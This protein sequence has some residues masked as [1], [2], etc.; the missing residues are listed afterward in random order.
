[1]KKPKAEVDNILEVLAT[2]RKHRVAETVDRASGI[3]PEKVRSR[4]RGHTKLTVE[5]LSALLA[6]MN[7]DPVEF[8]AWMEAGFHPE[9]YLR[10]L[11]KKR[12]SQVRHLRALASRAPAKE[13]SAE[14]IREQADGLED[15][16]PFDV[17]AAREGAL[18]I[19]RTTEHRPAVVDRDSLCEAW[20]IV[21]AIQRSRGRYSSAAYC[22]CRSLVMGGLDEV[23]TVRRALIFQ[24]IAYL[25]SDQGDFEHAEQVLGVAL[26]TSTKADEWRVVGRVLV[27]TGVLNG[28]RARYEEAIGAYERSLRLMPE[29]E[30]HACFSAYQGLGAAWAFRGELKESLANLKS[31]LAVLDALPSPPPILKGVVIWLR[32]EIQLLR[33][34]LPAAGRGFD[35]VREI[36]IDQ[37]MRPIDIALISLRLAKVLLLEGNHAEL[38]ELAHQM[39]ALLGPIERQNRLVSA[40]YAEFMSLTLRGK[41]TAE[42]L[43]SLYRR[44]H[45]DAQAAPP[46]LPLK[47][48]RHSSKRRVITGSIRDRRGPGRRGQT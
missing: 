47:K 26:L 4:L 36:Y 29:E 11:E 28:K 27:S 5:D 42:F 13:Y 44:M 37:G 7:V 15:L 12:P 19:L 33:D 2:L 22:L 34:D 48:R 31:A 14:E 8:A 3:S 17:D 16:R 18:E 10:K 38:N 24:R 6:A 30:W 20:G 25:L 39:F 21:G 45:G 9:V 41:L 43:E 1:M 40:A 46:L 32:A 35:E 23:S